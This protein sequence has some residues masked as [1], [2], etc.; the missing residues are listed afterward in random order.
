MIGAIELSID[1]VALG[2]SLL[3]A[4]ASAALCARFLIPVAQ[5]WLSEVCRG[6]HRGRFWSRFLGIALV[7]AVILGVIL[8]YVTENASR[9]PGAAPELSR[10]LAACAHM[11]RLSLYLGGVVILLFVVGVAALPNGSDI[12]A[13]GSSSQKLDH[14]KQ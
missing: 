10:T 2:G 5:P 1:G 11:L 7:L 3:I 6:E 12:A 13:S 9:A 14:G 4:G 8:G